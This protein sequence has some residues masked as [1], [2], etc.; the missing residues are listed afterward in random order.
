M[1]KKS[2]PGCKMEEMWRRWELVKYIVT[3]ERLNFR[4]S[5]EK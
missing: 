2:R 4:V 1:G 3:K 5:P